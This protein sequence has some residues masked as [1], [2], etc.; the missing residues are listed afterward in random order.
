M[1]SV[2]SMVAPTWCHGPTSGNPF[3]RMLTELTSEVTHSNPVIRL[4]KGKPSAFFSG[5][6]R[7][8]RLLNNVPPFWAP[9]YSELAA[10]SRETSFF[11]FARETDRCPS[12]L[13]DKVSG[14]AFR[15]AQIGHKQLPNL[16]ELGAQLIYPTKMTKR[17]RNLIDFGPFEGITHDFVFSTWN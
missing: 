2:I 5:L 9:S 8:S 14:H 16:H 15:Y 3:G 1:S 7:R 4:R 17:K 6:T 11:N 10:D 12:F 13:H